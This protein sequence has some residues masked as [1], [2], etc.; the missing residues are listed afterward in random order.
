M[1]TAPETLTHPSPETRPT[2]ATIDLGAFDRN[3]AAVNA[4]LPAGSRLVVVLKANAYGHGAVQLA[5]RCNAGNSAMIALALLEEALELRNAGITHPLLVLGPLSLEQVRLAI[6]RDVTI[7]VVGPEELGNVYAVGHPIGIHLKLDTGMGRMGVT[8]PELGGVIELLRANPQVRVEALY[9]HFANASDPD[10]PF[11]AEQ[12]ARF[13]R[14]AQRLAAAGIEPPLH[15]TANSAATFRHFERP[16]ELVRVGIALHGAEPLDHGG[17]RLEPLMRWRTAIAR[18]KELPAGAPVGYGGTFRTQRASRIAILPVGYAD[19][20]D[21]LLS[22]NADVLVHG[23][24]VPVIGRVSMDMVTIDV[25]DIPGIALGDEVVLL[26]RQGQ[27]E[28]AVEELARK[29]GTISHEVLC[30]VG[31]RVPRV[32]ES[33]Q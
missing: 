26:G 11:T 21:R 30:R 16:G 18:L 28:I 22:N 1:F 5:R 29:T 17:S 15:H 33:D 7:G 4:M 2:W 8:E 20:Y 10:D 27:S 3:L 31:A 9:T 24:R 23:Q 6:S 25:T 13:E 32:Y 12:L 19:G 14:M